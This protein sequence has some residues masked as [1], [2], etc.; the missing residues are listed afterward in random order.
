MTP[1]VKGVLTDKGF[2]NAVAA[3]QLFGGHGYIEEW[4]MSQFVRDARIAMIYGGANGIQAMDLI[5]RKLPKDGGRAMMGFLA[6]VQTFIKDHA[7]VEG[8]A[9]FTAPLQA[10]LNDL[11]GATMWFMQNAFSKPDNAGAGATDYM[12]LLGLVAMGYMWARIA[13]AAL[14]RI[15][16]GPSPEMDDKLVTGRFYMERTLPETAL[17]LVRIK[18]GAETTMALGAEAF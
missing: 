15:A 7:E 17:R 5:G 16:Q 8:M 1:V 14:A 2:D 13:K 6:E 3:Q 11:Q 10:G 12:H 9:P 4:G 18:A